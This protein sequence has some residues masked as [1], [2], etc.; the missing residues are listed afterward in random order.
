MA[1]CTPGPIFLFSW[2]HGSCIFI[3]QSTPQ[4]GWV[5]QLS[6]SQWKVSIKKNV[7]FQGLKQRIWD[8]KDPYQNGYI[9]ICPYLFFWLTWVMTATPNPGHTWTPHIWYSRATPAC[10][11]PCLRGA[12]KSTF[13]TPPSPLP[14]FP[15]LNC[16][17]RSKRFY[18]VLLPQ[19]YP[20]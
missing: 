7:P 3:C 11:S 8:Q 12:K 4:L 20:P 5:K 1:R 9:Y 15:S 16:P 14:S 19:P 17:E 10:V 2:T 13:L 18:C 6:F